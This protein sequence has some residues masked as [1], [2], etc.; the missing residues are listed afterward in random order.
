MTPTGKQLLSNFIHLCKSWNA[1][2][3]YFC[4]A[5]HWEI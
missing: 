5:S 2:S 4:F 1:R 3:F